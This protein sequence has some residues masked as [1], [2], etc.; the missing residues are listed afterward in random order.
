MRISTNANADPNHA[1]Q[2][3]SFPTGN[4]ILTV[5][6]I[7]IR[8]KTRA[9]HLVYCRK[10]LDRQNPKQVLTGYARLLGHDDTKTSIVEVLFQSTVWYRMDTPSID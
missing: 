9:L 5:W 4:H 6:K 1:I 8:K 3:R 2:F 10:I 7:F